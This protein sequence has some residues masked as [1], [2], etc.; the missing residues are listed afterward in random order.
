VQQPGL[1]DERAGHLPSCPTVTS[2]RPHFQPPLRC[3][4]P[5]ATS[6]RRRPST[7]GKA[8]AAGQTLPLPSGAATRGDYLLVLRQEDVGI[9]PAG[10]AGAAPGTLAARVGVRVYLGARQRFVLELA[11]SRITIDAPKTV[12]A[13]PGDMVTLTPS[14]E[15]LLLLP[16]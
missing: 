5:E 12:V 13:G 16:R 15:R 14:R 4:T 2:A 1:V 6:E 3:G 8:P 9:H 10:T 11:G 7:I